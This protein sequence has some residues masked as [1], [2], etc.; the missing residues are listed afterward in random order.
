MTPARLESIEKHS[1]T[2]Y[3][4]WF[5]LPQPLDYTAG[6]FV[7][8]FL[9]HEADERGTHR[10]FTLSSSP[11]E[12]LIAITTRN[13]PQQSSFKHRLFSLRP[14]DVVNVSQAMGD[15]VLPI[16]KSIP[17]I[18][19]VRGIGITPVRSMLKYLQDSGENRPV[20][21]IYSVK[22]AEDALFLDLIKSASMDLETIEL[23]SLTDTDLPVQKTLQEIEKNPNAR[24]YLS[25]PEQFVEKAYGELLANGLKASAI[26]TD[27]FHG[28]KS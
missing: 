20:S 26:V 4:F 14:G 12:S 7:E 25:G 2:T 3:T 18:F 22:H 11:S 6:Q 9:P 21:I 16:Q 8:I 13:V 10:W 15:F 28:Y 1:Q 19:L 27:Y 23:P 24:L 17:I 5:K